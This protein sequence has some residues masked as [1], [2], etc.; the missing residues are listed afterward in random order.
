MPAPSRAVELL[1]GKIRDAEIDWHEAHEIGHKE[2]KV[3]RIL[4]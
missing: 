2:Y 1:D 4:D 3:K